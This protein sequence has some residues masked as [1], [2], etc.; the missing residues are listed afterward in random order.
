MIG[1][2]LLQPHVAR[3]IV[4][5][6]DNEHALVFGQRRRNLLDELLLAL[7]VDRREQL[8]LVNRLKEILVLR[9]ALFFCVGKRR[10][11]PKIAFRFEFRRALIRQ[12]EQFV[13]G[14]HTR[15]MLARRESLS[16]SQ[17]TA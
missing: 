9:F 1:A 6:F 17:P 3:V 12:F 14:R 15:T 8:V 4:G 7:N 5:E 16:A 10:Y 13:W 11:V 2:F